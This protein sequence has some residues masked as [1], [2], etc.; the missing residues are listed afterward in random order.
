M[1][2]RSNPN[3]KYKVNHP[4]KGQLEVW[5]NTRQYLAYGVSMK[6]TDF[7]GRK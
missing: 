1:P 4:W 3:V 7:K 5:T 2:M 6:P